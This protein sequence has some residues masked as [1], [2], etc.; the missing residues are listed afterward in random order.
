MSGASPRKNQPRGKRPLPPEPE[1]ASPSVMEGL[2]RVWLRLERYSW[3]VLGVV[4][5]AGSA[6]TAPGVVEP[7]PGV[8]Y[9]ALGRIP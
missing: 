2:G 6:L 4:L 8:I 9:L 1:P 5:L 7:K 3:D